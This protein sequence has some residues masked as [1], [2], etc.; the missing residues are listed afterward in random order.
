[1]TRGVGPLSKALLLCFLRDRTVVL[2]TV[3]LPLMFLLLFGILF[4][5]GGAPRADVIQIGEVRLL[6]SLPADAHTDLSRVLKIDRNDDHSKALEAVR[7]GDAA[8]A[9]EQRGERIILRYSAADQV[10]AATVRSVIES[11]VQ[12]AN[13]AQAGILPLTSMQAEQVEDQSLKAIQFITPGLLGWAVAAN[14]SF[15]AALTLVGWR[16]NKLLRKLRLA[17][18]RTPAIL[19][20]RVGVSLLIAV[21]QMAIFIGVALLPYFGLK[22]TGQWWMVFPLIIV[23][24]LAFLSIG[25]LAGAFAKTTE[26][27]GAVVN[28]V[29]LPMAVL[30][31]SFFSL[32][33]APSWLRAISEALPL[34]HLND[35]MLDVMVRGGDP[36]SVLPEIGLLSGF[37][38]VVGTVAMRLIRWD[39][40]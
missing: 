2:F 20:A 30:S 28:L 37:A 16:Q 22:L 9:I 6:D 4:R 39:D 15:G 24:T 19:V 32:D 23:G 38:V 13:L 35:G 25:L 7:R 40:V 11:L 34:K 3:M 29:I 14:A 36:L 10:Q 1:M 17:A 33:N 18:V 5:N 31:G 27:A 21:G 8:A 26:A 12:D